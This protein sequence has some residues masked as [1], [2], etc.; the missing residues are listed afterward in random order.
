MTALRIGIAHA[1]L[2]AAPGGAERLLATHVRLLVE[3]GHDVR[4]TAFRGDAG[5]WAGRLHGAE[6]RCLNPR[7]DRLLRHPQAAAGRWL[8]TRHE[9]R[10][11]VIAHNFPAST[12]LGTLG[13]PAR[14]VWYCHE[15]PRQLHP[16]ASP[17]LAR[18]LR[19]GVEL[20]AVA[21]FDKWMHPP[22]RSRT[23][24]FA[25][26]ETAGID[27]EGIAGIDAIWANSAATAAAVRAVYGRDAE[28]I[29]PASTI[30]EAADAGGSDEL[31]PARRPGLRVVTVSRLS[32][33]KNLDGLLLG[34]ARYVHEHDGEATLD[35]VGSGPERTF[36]ERLAER[37]GIAGA[38]RF[39]GHLPDDEL[40]GVMSGC[41]AFAAL[42]FDEPFGMVFTEA[43]AAGL[44]VLGPDHGGPL[45]ILAGGRLGRLADPADPASI[46]DALLDLA[47]TPQPEQRRRREELRRRC[48]SLYGLS[49][50]REKLARHI[51][52]ILSP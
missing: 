33:I 48:A 44:L 23:G 39:R 27:R 29:H 22:R 31:A 51:R 34:F 42:P 7:S 15:P 52:S 25:K 19:D 37:Q 20:R 35:V 45:E 12:L 50:L 46:R 17:R 26:R 36:L 30:A 24:L 21:K 16:E 47:D 40:R 5:V 14:K 11:V 1:A 3:E 6:L 10:D 9:D 49:A 38:V 28:V 32:D 43:A 4:V 8:A 18:A 2:D 41:S 13:I